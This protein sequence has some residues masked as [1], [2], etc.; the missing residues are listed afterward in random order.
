[1][2]RKLEDVAFDATPGLDPKVHDGPTLNRRD[3]PMICDVR[4]AS[5]CTVVG[6]LLLGCGEARAPAGRTTRVDSAG[7]EVVSNAEA[8]AV[9]A[10]KR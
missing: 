9:V 1:M 7:I 3:L 6:L 4:M 10:R 2:A 5:C 8:K